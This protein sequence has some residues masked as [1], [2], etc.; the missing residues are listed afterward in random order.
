MNDSLHARKSG[1]LTI[2]E[3]FDDVARRHALH[4]ERRSRLRLQME[5]GLDAR[6]ARLP[7]QGSRLP[8]VRAPPDDVRAH[9]RVVGAIHPAALPRRGRA[10][11]GIT[12]RQ[13]VRRSLAAFREPSRA[14]SAGCGRTRARSSSSWEGSSRTSASGRTNRQLDWR[15]LDDPPH[16]GVHQL[17]GRPRRALHGRAGAVGAGREPERVRVDR[18]RQRRSERAE[19]RP[20]RCPRQPGHRLHRQL[21]PSCPVRLQGGPPDPRQVDRGA[22]HRCRSRTAAAA[23]AT[24]GPWRPRHE[25]MHAFGYSAQLTLPPLAVLWLAPPVADPPIA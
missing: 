18:R 19:L 21:L 25:P 23:W 9:V 4:R 7:A 3:E 8:P 13:D 6:H 11:Q 5:H 22:Q 15:L 20:A 16:A 10:S 1:V 12:A 2:A 24:W 17:I 14:C